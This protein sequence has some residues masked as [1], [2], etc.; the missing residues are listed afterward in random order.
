MGLFVVSLG[1]A[2]QRVL[3][4]LKFHRAQ[5]AMA[6]ELMANHVVEHEKSRLSCQDRML[7]FASL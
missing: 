4:S 2:Q 1:C 3:E 7:R 5:S 6:I